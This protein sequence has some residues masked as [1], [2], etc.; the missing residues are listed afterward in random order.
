MRRTAVRHLPGG[1]SACLFPDTFSKRLSV[2]NKPGK[3]RCRRRA[4][5]AE[6]C[7]MILVGGLSSYAPGSKLAE[8]NSHMMGGSY[9]RDYAKILREKGIPAYESTQAPYSSN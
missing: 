6:K 4:K 5:T 7:P 9:Y 2:V 1:G 8:K 3:H